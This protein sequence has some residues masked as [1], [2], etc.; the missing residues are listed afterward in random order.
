MS[1]LIV[2]SSLPLLLIPTIAWSLACTDSSLLD[3]LADATSTLDTTE[4]VA[5]VNEAL[6]TILASEYAAE[7][8]DEV[9]AELVVD[10]TIADDIYENVP[11]VGVSE[12]EV[13]IPDDAA[14]TAP[15]PNGIPLL[16]GTLRGRYLYA[17]DQA[18]DANDP[19]GAARRP[20]QHVGQFRGEW[21][22]E[23]GTLSGVF[24]GRCVDLRRNE[25]PEDLVAGGVFRGV[26]LGNGGEV[27]G[28][29]KGRYGQNSSGEGHFVGRWVDPDEHLLGGVRGR[30]QDDPNAAGGVI[31]GHWV[32]FDICREAE[33]LPPFEFDPN[34]L[35]GMDEEWNA[36]PPAVE[37]ELALDEMAADANRPEPLICDLAPAAVFRGHYHPFR[38]DPNDPN[39]ERLP[40]G[41]L[42]G[43]WMSPDEPPQ[44]MLGY[45]MSF[46]PLD[47]NG[48]P[49]LPPLPPD[50]NDPNVIPPDP[51]DPNFIAPDPNAPLVEGPQQRPRLLGVFYAKLVDGDGVTYGYLRGVYGVSRHQVGVLR[52][53][54]LS[55]DSELIG[56]LR[57]HWLPTPHRPGGPFR[58]AA[59]YL[60]P[61]AD[62]VALALGA[63]AP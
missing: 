17:S 21:L 2:R 61:E 30:W 36:L 18:S 55:M 51:N 32:R 49:P 58:G 23:D 11:L 38:P 19:N 54:W 53:E 28:F 35:G 43:L 20:I 60:D 57:G 39:A 50:P 56:V 27:R 6:T 10:G 22:N 12:S 34:D 25:L 8:D 16:S 47:P 5:S 7:S 14:F 33:S 13:T 40:G 29:L 15:D 37:V 46:P 48:V 4:L 41:W 63:Q 26:Y 3:Q 45:Y 59:L 31:A 9:Q 44:A 52:A 42:R 1:K 24:H 62:P